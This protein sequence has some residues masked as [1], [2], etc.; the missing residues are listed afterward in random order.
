MDLE[1]IKNHKD[2]RDSFNLINV[3]FIIKTLLLFVYFISS[4]QAYDWDKCRRSLEKQKKAAGL[5][6]GFATTTTFPVQYTSSWGACSAIGKPE[7]DRKAFFNDNFIMLVTDFSR[8]NG[9]YM[10]AFMGFYKCSDNGEE[11]FIKTVRS[12]YEVI[13]GKLHYLSIR[14][15]IHPEVR[16]K[17]DRL[18]T[19]ESAFNNIQSTLKMNDITTRECRSMEQ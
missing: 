12:N 15:I 2:L 9:E 6:G 13:F 19:P 8:G 14:E 17:E 18:K 1:V 5:N 4:A 3:K 11:E 7:D 16:K 10:K